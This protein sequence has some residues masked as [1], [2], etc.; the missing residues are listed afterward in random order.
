M[1]IILLSI[2]LACL[3]PLY[4]QTICTPSLGGGYDCYDYDQ[5][6]YIDIRPR[7]GAGTYYYP[8]YGEVIRQRGYGIDYYAPVYPREIAPRLGAGYSTYNY[9]TGEF[10]TITPRLGG[11]FTIDKY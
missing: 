2:L 10:G 7:L 8:G 11:G 5:G 6:T 3:N 9:D 1:R 4:A